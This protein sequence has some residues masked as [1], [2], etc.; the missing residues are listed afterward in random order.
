MYNGDQDPVVYKRV[1]KITKS[2]GFGFHAWVPAMVQAIR[3]EI[4]LMI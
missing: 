1:G 4:K 3:D 2:A